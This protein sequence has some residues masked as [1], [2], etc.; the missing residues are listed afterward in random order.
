MTVRSAAKTLLILAIALPT[1]GA[2][3]IWVAGL[4]Q[5]MGDPAGVRILF[6]VGVCCEVVWSV[7]LVGLV[8]LLAI[9][10]LNEPP[11]S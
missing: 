6:Y 4:L 3:L 2:V 10:T 11:E 7:S 8:I 5:A 1:V 9:I